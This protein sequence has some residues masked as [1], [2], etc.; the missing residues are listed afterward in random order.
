MEDPGS[1]QVNP[2]MYPTAAQLREKGVQV[3]PS[4]PDGE[5]VSP[6]THVWKVDAS[7]VLEPTPVV[8]VRVVRK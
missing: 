7:R 5:T 4:I 1:H 8:V 3:C 6:L 2:A